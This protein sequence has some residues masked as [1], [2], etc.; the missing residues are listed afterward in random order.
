MAPMH[1]F[2][3]RVV[4]PEVPVTVEPVDV[5]V[6]VDSVTVEPVDVSVDVDVEVDVMVDSSVLLLVTQGLASLISAW[7]HPRDA[8]GSMKV[9]CPRPSVSSTS[10]VPAALST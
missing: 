5:S 2:V 10:Y 4:A 1:M 6:D 3:T 9:T 8:G 7:L